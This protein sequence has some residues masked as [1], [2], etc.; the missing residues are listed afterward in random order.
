MDQND[1]ILVDLEGGLGPAI[2]QTWAVRERA[3]RPRA[4][5]SSGRQAQ[6]THHNVGPG[7]R[8]GMAARVVNHDEIDAAGLLA[9]GREP[10][11]RAAT[12]DRLTAAHHVAQLGK[13]RLALEPRHHELPDRRRVGRRPYTARNAAAT[14]AAN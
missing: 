11:P 1:G 14:A 12:D 9:L 7:P 6:M 3:G 4:D 10:G 13:E 8:H 5:R 2:D